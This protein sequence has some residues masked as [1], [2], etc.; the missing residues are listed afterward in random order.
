[1]LFKTIWKGQLY[2]SNRKNK[3]LTLPDIL[4][5]PLSTYEAKEIIKSD[6]SAYTEFQSCEPKYQEQILEFIQGN[7]GLP[8]LY[9]S[10][11][12]TVMDPINTPERLEAF[13]S[14]LLGQ[15]VKIIDVLTKE[16]SQLTELGSLVIMDIIVQIEDGSF[17][18]IEM[19]KYGYAF[20]GERSSCYISDL[21]MRQY[22]R[23]KS[24][25]Q[26]HFS[27]KDMKPVY[28]I[29]LMEKS[30]KE[31]K[32]VSP[33]YLHRATHIF[34]TGVKLNLLANYIYI[35]LDTFHSVSQNIDTYLD[36]WLTFLSSDHPND[37]IRLV[38][39]YPEFIDYYHDIALFRKKP[40]ELM[41][42]FSKALLT[43]DKNTANYM[44]EEQAK[45]YEAK[46]AEKDSLLIAQ[47]ARIAELE[48][49]LKEK[50]TKN[51]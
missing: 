44:I 41:S 19:Q 37:I 15:A 38:E 2:M 12:K 27:F 22:N 18:D 40:K 10:F 36:A 34:D 6:S 35:S 49:Q 1:M 17:V 42:M 33:A 8:I 3:Q 20:T 47:E 25:K 14:L 21:I 31:F 39:N 24:I 26:K 28:L 4:G 13:L 23:T 32:A 30:S 5:N 50:T 45:E 7:R 9:D 29:V 11:F 48:A 16:G 43:M 46:L 51:Q